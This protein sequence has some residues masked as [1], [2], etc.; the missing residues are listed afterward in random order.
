[1]G[2]VS[3]GCRIIHE[4]AS[5]NG[6]EVRVSVERSITNVLGVRPTLRYGKKPSIEFVGGGVYDA[7]QGGI[8]K[9]RALQPF[10]DL[11]AALS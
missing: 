10:D 4:N 2:V 5:I 11:T 8:V 3:L 7:P 9:P 6:G 1:M